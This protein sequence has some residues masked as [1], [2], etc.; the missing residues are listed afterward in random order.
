MTGFRGDRVFSAGVVFSP[1]PLIGLGK[2]HVRFGIPGVQPFGMFE[3][4][5]GSLNIL[6]AQQHCAKLG[7]RAAVRFASSVMA[8]V[9]AICASGSFPRCIYASPRLSYAGEG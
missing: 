4:H 5:D 6:A 1:D 2:N 7:K 9:K 8:L 3:I